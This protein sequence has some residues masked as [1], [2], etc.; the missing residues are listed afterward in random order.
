M[1]LDGISYRPFAFQ[2]NMKNA[3]IP[4]DA[5]KIIG[6]EKTDLKSDQIALESYQ[7][8]IDSQKIGYISAIDYVA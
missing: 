4:Y 6:L 7:S 1:G 3:K 2:L 5:S 8:A